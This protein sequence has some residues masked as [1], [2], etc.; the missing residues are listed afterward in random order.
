MSRKERNGLEKLKLTLTWVEGKITCLNSR[1]QQFTE[2][3]T[4]E[5]KSQRLASMVKHFIH[6]YQL[7]QKYQLTDLDILV[8]CEV[9][10][11]HIYSKTQTSTNI[12]GDNRYSFKPHL[13]SFKLYRRKFIVFLSTV[14][15]DN[16]I[17]RKCISFF[18][19]NHRLTKE[20][21]WDVGTYSFLIAFKMKFLE[22][23]KTKP[24]IFF[25]T[26]WWMSL[27][28]FVRRHYQIN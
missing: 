19:E 23:L 14:L 5:M 25:C 8:T 2:W 27:N 15:I 28:I 18:C 11:N 13:Y 26:T 17:L 22:F 12:A 4:L 7:N 3:S 21:F 16:K 9:L 20:N 6:V 24:F 10:V 1:N